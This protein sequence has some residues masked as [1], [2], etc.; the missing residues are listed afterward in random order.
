M[1]T[2]FAHNVRSLSKDIDGIVSGNT[3][4]NS[5]VILNTET[6][7]NPSDSTCKIIQALIF[8]NIDFNNT[9]NRILTLAY[10]YRHDIIVCDKFNPSGVFKKHPLPTEYSL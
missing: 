10:G 6:Q 4:M 7:I 1:I 9:E 3:I 8:F 2:A 5:D